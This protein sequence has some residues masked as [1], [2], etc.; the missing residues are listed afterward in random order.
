V[1]IG[2]LLVVAVS[3]IVFLV[4][5]LHRLGGTVDAQLGDEA[6]LLARIRAEVPFADPQSALL[7]TSG[8]AALVHDA[9]KGWMAVKSVGDGVAF[10]PLGTEGQLVWGSDQVRIEPHD[11]VMPPFVLHAS[12]DALAAFRTRWADPS[13]RT[14]GGAP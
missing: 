10:R 11:L 9:K 1:S 2:V 7:D 13:A 6:S 3:G 14:A 12:P 4:F 5:V 8:H